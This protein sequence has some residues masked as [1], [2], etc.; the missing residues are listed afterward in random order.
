MSQAPSQPH[1]ARRLGAIA[2][3]LLAGIALVAAHSAHPGAV[4]AQGAPPG[5]AATGGG[6]TIGTTDSLQS[7]TLQEKRRFL[8][9]L[10]PS[11]RDT[12][13]TPRRYPVLYLLDGDAHF[14]SVTGLIQ[15]LGTGVNG[16]YV[17][18]EMIVVAITNT[19]RMRDMTPT[20][21]E[22]GFDG[23]PSPAFRTSGGMD[24]FLSFI[25]DE[26]IPRIDSQ[27]RT[28][29]YRVLVGHSLGGITAIH[30]LYTIPQTFGAY[31]AI[32]PSLW[33]DKTLLLKQARA[34]VER[35]GAFTNRALF[36]AQANTIN[37]ADTTLNTHFNAIS[38]FDGVVRAY[39]Q[40]GL[41]YDFRYY[42]QDSH[43]SVPLIAEYDALRFIFSGYDLNLLRVMERP[44]LLREH[45]ARLSRELGYDHPP[46][47]SM[48]ELMA[49][50]AMQQDQAKSLA[51]RALNAELYPSS[52]RAHEALAGAYL[53]QGDTA[54]A[55]ASIRTTLS[56]AP[57]RRWS[58]ETLSRLTG[59]R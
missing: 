36:V 17:L 6:I 44:T 27:Y 11:Y 46:P 52:A 14:H 58:K 50:V 56:L 16:T 21:V 18:P 1:L 48:V 15:I 3:L 33:W 54:R 51:F 8:V 28:A 4:A 26:L 38:Q 5:A 24:R 13:Y 40:S 32:D 20:R 29:P 12:T 49:I 37:P 45:F 43:G 30:A 31:V 39:N 23:K 10:P 7:R 42:P 25:K 19:D 35:P 41:R 55:V 59:G 9:Y 22:T 2:P 47:E 57:N 34:K 53:A